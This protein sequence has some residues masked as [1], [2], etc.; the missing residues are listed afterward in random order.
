MRA[1][2][3]VGNVCRVITT[4]LR[5]LVKPCTSS[6]RRQNGE[7]AA[8]LVVFIVKGRTVAQSMIKKGIQAAGVW[9]RFEMYT[10]VGPDSR[11]ELCCSW[12]HIENKYS[13]NLV[14]GSWSSHHRTSD[15]KCNVVGT[16]ANQASLWGHTLEKSPNCIAYQI[17][18]S[19]WCVKKTSAAKAV[20]Q[21]CKIGLAG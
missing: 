12:G 16:T 11:C 6:E 7:I 9:Y 4:E 1:D 14:C 2:F 18:F 8:S 20:P 13:S 15:H 21:S 17:T 3:A 10:N 5:W 19:S